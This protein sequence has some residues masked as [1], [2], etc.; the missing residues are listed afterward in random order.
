M[1]PVNCGDLSRTSPKGTERKCSWLQSLK[2]DYA[3]EVWRDLSKRGKACE[4]TG[5]VS[6]VE[7]N[8]SFKSGMETSLHESAIC[9]I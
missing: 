2:K 6:P 9:F 4:N 8:I 7:F 1:S 5:S 3:D